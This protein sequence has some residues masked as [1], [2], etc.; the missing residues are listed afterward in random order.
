MT[1]YQKSDIHGNLDAQKMFTDLWYCYYCFCGGRG[2]G[3]I[4][5]PLIGGEGKELCLHAKCKLTEVG[6]PLCG[7]LNVFCCITEQFQFPPMK[8]SPMCVCCNKE[9]AGASGGGW[10]PELF[11]F[12]TNFKDTGF[13]VVYVF[14]C[15]SALHAPGANGR[16]F[17]GLKQKVICIEE[18]VKMVA[19]VEDGVLC[20]GV[21]TV[22]CCWDQCAM[23]PAE[24]NPTIKCL[25][26]PKKGSSASAAP[27]SYGKPG[28]V[29]M[30]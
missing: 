1:K 12:S 13:W 5:N 21:S 17:F 3:D 27:M 10:K 15:G 29:E 20:S 28:Q 14:C 19:P 8:D 25:G 26:F 2:V 6:D 11:D 22:L 4:S 24:N 30:S 9:L 18:A 16:P 7:G 23:P